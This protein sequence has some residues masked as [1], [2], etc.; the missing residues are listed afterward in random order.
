[1]AEDRHLHLIGAF[2]VGAGVTDVLGDPTVVLEVYVVGL[3]AHPARFA[4]A[5]DV[6]D[7]LA[8]A[9]AAAA[10]EARSLDGR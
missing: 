5:P 10:A 6:A 3:L 4:V 9:L 7:Q 2:E 1:M 8:E